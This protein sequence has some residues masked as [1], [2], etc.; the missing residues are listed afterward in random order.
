MLKKKVVIRSQAEPSVSVKKYVN[1]QAKRTP[2]E[3][4]NEP[5]AVCKVI[6][7]DDDLPLFRVDDADDADVVDFFVFAPGASN[8][9]QPT[10]KC[11][12]Y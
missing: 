2:M 4:P 9:L 3:K 12:N 1:A 11:Q 6:K 10:T 7:D 5:Q 8:D